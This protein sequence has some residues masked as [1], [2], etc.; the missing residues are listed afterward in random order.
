MTT[1]RAL[2]QGLGAAAALPAAARAKE[3]L[4]RDA[5]CVFCRIEAGELPATIVWRDERC[6]AIADRW[7][8]APGHTLLIPRTHVENLYTLPPDLAAHLYAFAPRLARELKRAFASDGLTCLQNN[9]VA[10]G[11]SVFHFHMHFI[12]RRTGVEIFKRIGE[13]P[14]L[15]DTERERI[16]APL[17]DALA[18]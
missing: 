13:R 3:S 14:E 11:Q 6:I 10:G 18:G 7:P 4:V 12:P 8:F 15:P 16:F 17:R 2:L 9:E 1:R 5:G